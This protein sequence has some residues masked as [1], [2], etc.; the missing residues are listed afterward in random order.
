[1]A[2]RSHPELLAAQRRYVG[3]NTCTHLVACAVTKQQRDNAV[4]LMRSG[5]ALDAYLGAAM[6]SGP[7]APKED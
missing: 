6:M 5:N 4:E 3:Q 7:C 1:M 2:G